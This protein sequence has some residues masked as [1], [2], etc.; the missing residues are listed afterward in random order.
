MVKSN[1]IQRGNGAEIERKDFIDI[2]NQGT[3][4]GNFRFVKQICNS[5]LSK[6]PNDLAIE[7][8]FIRSVIFENE[9]EKTYELIK[10]PILEKEI[11]I[12]FNEIHF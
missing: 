8:I 6:F 5:W 3:K 11:N 7:C 9:K 2:L 4:S 10:V 1:N 12:L